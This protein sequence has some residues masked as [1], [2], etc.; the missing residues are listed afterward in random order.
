MIDGGGALTSD[1]AAVEFGPES[2]GLFYRGEGNWLV[3]RA[4]SEGR[5]HNEEI[6][7]E[8]HPYPTRMK[9]APTVLTGWQGYRFAVFFRGDDDRLHWKAYTG[10]RWHS[11]ALIEAGGSL[12]S[13]PGV[14]KCVLQ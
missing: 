14:V 5:W 10:D 8:Q 12:T 3:W 9:S 11:D 6:F 2:L 7:N 13:R 4:Y 1:S